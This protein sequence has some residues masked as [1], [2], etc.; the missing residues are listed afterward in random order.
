MKETVAIVS[1]AVKPAATQAAHS[2]AASTSAEDFPVASRLLPARLRRPVIAFYCFARAADDIA[3]APAQS[4]AAK[5]AALDRLEV[6]LL[7]G[8]PDA[9][10]VATML[11]Q[12]LGNHGLAPLTALD[13][14]RAFR[15]DAAGPVQ[16]RTWDDLIDYC[17]FSAMPVGRFLLALH[18]EHDPRASRASDAL[19]AALQILNHL[20]D[21]KADHVERRRIYL[22]LDWLEEADAQPDML[23]G[24]TTPPAL[25]TVLRRV[26]AA[27]NQLIED[28]RPLPRH[29]SSRGLR[30]QAAVTLAMA[31]A[32]ARLIARADPL[33]QPPRLNGARRAWAV[34]AGLINGVA[35]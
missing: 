23:C 7:S 16:C 28:A 25:R 31:D 19:C 12:A 22:P 20:R 29:I 1:A 5:L 32:H 13:L 18:G 27:T 9:P 26:L 3:D 11:G 2:R 8:G 24:D 6:G 10:P 33:A 15:F 17:R 30:L 21:C 34:A 14:L 35:R 4:S